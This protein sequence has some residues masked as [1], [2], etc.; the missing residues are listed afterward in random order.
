M[1]TVYTQIKQLLS[2]EENSIKK[3]VRDFFL[4][5]VI[6]IRWSDFWVNDIDDALAIL[7]I[8]NS[9]KHTKLTKDETKIMILFEEITKPWF[10]QLH[11]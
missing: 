8:I 1:D 11:I 3:M 9:F 2:L 7:V 10:D 5:Q 4:N 6:Y